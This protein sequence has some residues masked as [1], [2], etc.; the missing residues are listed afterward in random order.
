MIYFLIYLFLEVLLST[1]IS[2]SIGGL[3]TFLEILLSAFIGIALLVNFRVKLAENFRE[4]SLNTMN[5]QS[6]QKLNLFAL[7]G[8]IFL[9]IPGFL[10]DFIGLFMQFSI[11][12]S[13]IVNPSNV[14]STNSKSNYENIYKQKDSNVIDVEIISDNSSLK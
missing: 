4:F 3:L 10:T 9:I 1:S 7:V 14:K 12:T 11:F 5:F 13:M 8:A 6:L 2:S